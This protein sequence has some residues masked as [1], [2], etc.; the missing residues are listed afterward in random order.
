[1]LS[2][3]SLMGCA[4]WDVGDSQERVPFGKYIHMRT[5]YVRLRILVGSPK[6]REFRVE[7]SCPRGRFAFGVSS[8]G[9]RV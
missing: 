5:E 6:G 9:F 4:V 2:L 8:L 3:V 1:M 7:R